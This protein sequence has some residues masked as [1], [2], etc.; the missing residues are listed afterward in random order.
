LT[1]T[2]RVSQGGLG[3]SH[4]TLGDALAVMTRAGG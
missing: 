3:Q 1:S 2:W 4:D